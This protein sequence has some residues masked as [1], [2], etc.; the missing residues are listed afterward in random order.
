MKRIILVNLIVFFSTLMAAGQSDSTKKGKVDLIKYEKIYVIKTPENPYKKTP[1]IQINSSDILSKIKNVHPRMFVTKDW[2][3]ELKKQY[4]SDKMLQKYLKNILTE[5]EKI[6]KS[7]EKK[8]EKKFL[9]D[10]QVLGLAYHWTG[11]KKFAEKATD[12]MLESST[13]SYWGVEFLPIADAALTIGIGYDIFYNY[14]DDDT[15][16]TI[17][18]GIIKNGLYPGIAAYD[19]APFGWFKDVHHNWNI[20]CNSALIISS[21]A[22]AE[23]DPTF[24]YF[25]G[26]IVPEAVKSMA[27]AFNEYALDELSPK[28]R[29]IGGMQPR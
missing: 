12:F 27:T 15:R 8:D 1:V 11:D 10:M 14:F 7:T 4:S 22:I 3:E 26:K 16:N 25:A 28:E 6:Y 5:A 21:L 13:K 9:T 17:R 18:V 29:A 2:I 19:G 23:D 20:V 24:N